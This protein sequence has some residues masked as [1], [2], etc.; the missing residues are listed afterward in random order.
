M[1]ANDNGPDGVKQNGRVSDETGPC[2]TPDG[3]NGNIK[4]QNVRN[5]KRLI[6]LLTLLLV[7]VSASAARIDTVAVYS[8]RMQRDIAA[9]VVVPDAARDDCRMPTLYLLHGYGGSHLAWLG[10]TDLRRLA[11]GFG[12]IL[13]CPDGENSWYWD[14][15][16][17]PRSQFETFVSTELVD[18]I[19]A[20]YP[21]IPAREGRAI[22]GL[23][24]GG[25]GALWI[26]LR[27]KD[28]FG[29]AGSTSGGVDIRPFPDS[30]EIKTQLGE[31]RENP[32]RWRTHTVIE[33]VDSL[34]NGEL[35][36][37]FDCGYEDFFYPV[38]L[39]LHDKLLKLGVGHDFQVR[40]GE[41]NA[42]YWATSLPSQMLFFY[43]YFHPRQIE[44]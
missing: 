38:N 36:L 21:T 6:G 2:Q 13:V 29:A 8:S 34:R 31:E 42:A 3:A 22:T 19:D 18:W 26:A 23:S 17:D 25:H 28:R 44:K 37:I 4:T 15:P 5:M 30:W 7:A 12:M 40:P 27:H 20:R 9:T 14:S 41:H 24:M 43:R 11:D 39:N 1:V 32:E 16:L 33:Q 35:A 10:I